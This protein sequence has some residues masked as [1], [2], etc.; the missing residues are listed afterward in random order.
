MYSITIFALYLTSVF[1]CIFKGLRREPGAFQ[2]LKSTEAFFLASNLSCKTDSLSFSVDVS[3]FVSMT[4]IQLLKFH[5]SRDVNAD[6]LEICDVYALCS[7]ANTGLK[8]FFRSRCH[9]SRLRLQYCMG[10]IMP[11]L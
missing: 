8:Y 5:R 6:L 9:M 7:R 4:L 3:F 11:V 10:M 1:K 2:V